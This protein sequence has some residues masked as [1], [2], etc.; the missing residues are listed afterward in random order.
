MKVSALKYVIALAVVA[1]SGI[2]LMQ[3]SIIK[4]A[5]DISERQFRERTQ[6]ALREVAWQLLAASGETDKFDSVEP[7]EQLNSHYFLVNVN[8]LI[9][10][11]ILRHQLTEQL[12]RHD[13]LLDFEYA[14]FDNQAGRMTIK[15][16]VCMRPGECDQLPMSY[17]P[18]SDRFV[19]YFAVNFPS[20]APYLNL[21]LRGWYLMT[22][23]LLLVLAFF[24]YSLWAISKQ[25]RLSETQKIFINNL[26]HELKTPVSS[27]SLAAKVLSNPEILHTPERLFRYSRI[28]DEQSSRLTANIEK[29]LHVAMLDKRRVELTIEQVEIN[30][31][32][33][34]TIDSFKQS[35]YGKQSAIRFVPAETE[36]LVEAD[37]FHLENI[38]Q[39]M[40]ENGIKYCTS[41]PEIT[42]ALAL[43]QRTIRLSIADNGIGIP[44]NLRKKIF[45]K[46]YR[47][48]TG[49][50]HNVKGF[51]IGLNYV[52]KMVKAHKWQIEVDDNPGG[53]TIFTLLIPYR[54]AHR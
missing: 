49:D 5:Y 3:L 11:E 23:L 9:D 18:Q 16:Y 54:Y 1:V 52:Y 42:V 7:V 44:A 27:I 41:H 35:E 2:L 37:L 12:K 31:F 22:A 48:P 39:N 43:E 15:E 40:I 17:F 47:V 21:K 6:V 10:P 50:V 46:F 38:L 29:V 25:R 36:I 26:T 28:I 14:I 24:G 8:S 45:K 32:L 4:N 51:G 53:G 33:A 13:L 19:Y 20:L 30:R 34:E